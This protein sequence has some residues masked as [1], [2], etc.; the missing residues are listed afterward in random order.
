M[1]E[2]SGSCM[3][4]N[5]SFKANG[6]P[7]FMANCHCTD[8]RKATGAAYASFVFMKTGDV[9]MTGTAGSYQHTVESG[10]TLT[11]YFCHDC[12][13]PTHT[14]NS[15]RPG[16]VGL[17]AGVINEQEIVKPQVNVYAGS[18][19]DSTPLDPNIPAPEKMPG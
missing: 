12:G 5:I 15:A 2:F 3:C 8:C 4:G 14:G 16:L 13:S 11:K 10:N 19:M 6:E 1:T 7:A 17:R 9:K 18:K